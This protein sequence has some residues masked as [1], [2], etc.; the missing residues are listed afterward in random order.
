MMTTEVEEMRYY[1]DGRQGNR[2]EMAAEKHG[3]GDVGQRGQ[4]Q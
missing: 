3:G 4:R 2:A 1:G